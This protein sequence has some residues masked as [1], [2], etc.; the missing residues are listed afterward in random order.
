MNRVSNKAAT[1]VDRAPDAGP[2]LGM[3][4]LYVAL[5]AMLLA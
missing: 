3:T 2:L 4:L 5:L 1:D